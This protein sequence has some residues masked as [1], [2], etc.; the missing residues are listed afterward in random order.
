MCGLS[1]NLPYCDGS[2][3]RTRDEEAGKTYVYDATGHRTE[4]PAE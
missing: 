2:H 4:I 3:K 1:A